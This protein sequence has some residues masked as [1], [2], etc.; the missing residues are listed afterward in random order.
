MFAEKEIFFLGH[1]INSNGI[2]SS[3]NKADAIKNFPQPRTVKELRRFLGHVIYYRRFL[4]AA[5]QTLAPLTDLLTEDEVK[6]KRLTWNNKAAKAFETIKL[7]IAD[8]TMLSFPLRDA[9]TLLT[10]DSSDSSA[11]AILSQVHEGLEQPLAFFS[12]IFS[13]VQRTYS[14]FNRELLGAYLA[15]KH[16]KCIF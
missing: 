10:V 9:K 7:Q 12:K 16:F 14:A 13:S 4:K 8:E 5:S 6:A 3:P 11:G 1:E 15:V 2:K